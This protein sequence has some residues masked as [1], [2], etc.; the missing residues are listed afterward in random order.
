VSGSWKK[1]NKLGMT[2]YHFSKSFYSKKNKCHHEVVVSS[3]PVVAFCSLL[4][5]QTPVEMEEQLNGGRSHLPLLAPHDPMGAVL[6]H[7]VIF[8]LFSPIIGFIDEQA[9]TDYAVEMIGSTLRFGKGVTKVVIT[10]CFH[11]K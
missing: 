8:N 1:S 9:D 3:W 5:K 4:L 2:F 11:V 10:P 6:C 7:Q